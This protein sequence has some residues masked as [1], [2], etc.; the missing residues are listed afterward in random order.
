MEPLV[1]NEMNFELTL[2]LGNL[3]LKALF[4]INQ[5]LKHSFGSFIS[6]IKIFKNLHHI[7]KIFNSN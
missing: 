2:Y 4:K 3:D 7:M 5:I 6:F 1:L